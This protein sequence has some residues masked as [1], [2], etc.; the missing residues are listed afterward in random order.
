MIEDL[1]G[2]LWMIDFNVRFPAW[3][4]ASSFSG[5]NLPAMLIEHAM[6]NDSIKNRILADGSKPDCYS[7][8]PG[9]REASQNAG[10]AFTRSTIEIPRSNITIERTMRLPTCI[11]SNHAYQNKGG[12]TV[13]TAKND[14]PIPIL[15]ARTLTNDDPNT[16]DE[17]YLNIKSS[18]LISDDVDKVPANSTSKAVAGVVQSV[19]NDVAMLCAAAFA[20]LESGPCYTPRRILCMTSV[21][22]SL[23][24]HQ[25]VFEMAARQA[26]L[27]MSKSGTRMH[28]IDLQLC[29]SVKVYQHPH[30]HPHPHTEQNKDLSHNSHSQSGTIETFLLTALLI[31][32]HFLHL[33]TQPHQAVL[34]AAGERQYVAE[35]ISLAEVH[36]S[37]AAGFTIEQIVLT[38][39]GKFYDISGA[40]NPRPLSGPLRAIF[41]DSLA[42]LK[43]IMKRVRDP[44]DWL[45][46]NIVGVRWIPS[47]HVL[48]RFGLDPKDP[49][50]VMAAADLLKDL[51]EGKGVG[52]HFHF[53]SS[54]VGADTWFG[55]AKA[56]CHFSAQFTKIINRPIAAID[57]GG[58]WS[59]HFYLK[60]SGSNN[61]GLISILQSIYSSFN[62]VQSVLPSV[63]FEP[64]KC[65]T[66]AAG[67][68]IT[69][70]LDIREVPHENKKMIQHSEEG[71]HEE[72]DDDKTMQ[73]II[74]DTCI[75]EVS[76]P[77][78]HPIFW[79][80]KSTIMDH[81]GWVPLEPGK[82]AIW[83]RTCMEFDLLP[84][85]FQ[86]PTTMQPGDY[87][88]VAATGSYDF[89]NSYD[90]GDGIARLITLV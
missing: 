20:L 83:G 87:L 22:E 10:A 59:P 64:G 42:D 70:I 46:C 34:M 50:V 67:G 13:V 1:S 31:N 17:N 32:Y 35:C 82:S 53:A 54:T 65:I 73:A 12:R 80:P 26:R 11:L 15:P 7:I 25:K 4:F 29:L 88:L 77:H 89:T 71:K 30:P 86:I 75:A 68:I 85:T 76:S 60:D 47:W 43:V 40:P 57:F 9:K 90:F 72:G 37:L 55:L 23:E 84:G 69:R 36:A 2:S 6:Y 16:A 63:Q 62:P 18:D 33:Q 44:N 39:P 5:C 24:R 61:S 8:L 38:G 58:G 51:P 3:I 21:A 66:E 49:D 79:K 27:L 19:E 41:A 28:P 74:V 78:I 81:H 45:D 14:N 48:S 52:M 56:F